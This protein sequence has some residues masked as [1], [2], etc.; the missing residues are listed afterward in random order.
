MI[1]HDHCEWGEN[2]GNRDKE[3]IRTY[4]VEKSLFSTKEGSIIKNLIT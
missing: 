1:L 2:E 3:I 4:Y